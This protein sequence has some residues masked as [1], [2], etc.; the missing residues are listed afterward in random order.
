[1]IAAQYQRETPTLNGSCYCAA[2]TPSHRD[3]AINV[4]EL[5]VSDITHLLNRHFDITLIFNG[6]TQFLQLIL[7]VGITNGT[8]T[9]IHTT[10]PGAKVTRY[11]DQIYLHV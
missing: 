9:H 5:G 6:I 7:Q 4:F 10:T 2:N 11:T 8:G 1:M 3:D